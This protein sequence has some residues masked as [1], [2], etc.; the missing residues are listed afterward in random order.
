MSFL[1][2]EDLCEKVKFNRKVYVEPVCGRVPLRI[3]MST[4]DHGVKWRRKHRLINK[5]GTYDGFCKKGNIC[6]KRNH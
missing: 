6:G 1:L 2:M 5:V 3:G 4:Y